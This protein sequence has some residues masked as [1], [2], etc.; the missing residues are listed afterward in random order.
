MKELIERI[1]GA[2][3]PSRELDA[4]IA[5]AI[6]VVPAGAFRPCAALDVATFATGAYGFWTAEAYTASLDAAMTLVLEGWAVGSLD[7]W[8][9][10]KSSSVTLLETGAFSNGMTGHD[11]DVHR[12]A[13]SYAATPALALAAAAL[14]ARGE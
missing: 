4:E 11:F 7:W 2:E 1:E 13:R 3:G 8:P 5:L 14:K 10:R 6:G 9:S 12:Q